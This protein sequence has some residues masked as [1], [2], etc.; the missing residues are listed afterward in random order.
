MR[1]TPLDTF[2]SPIRGSLFFL[3]EGG[4][5]GIT[6]RLVPPLAAP[7]SR[8]LL[9]GSLAAARAPAEQNMASL[10][11]NS[12]LPP[13]CAPRSAA[14]QPL[15]AEELDKMH[16]VVQLARGVQGPSVC[17][18]SLVGNMPDRPSAP[19]SAAGKCYLLAR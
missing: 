17:A 2:S 19:R 8:W 1:S 4:E 14:G 13:P 10:L 15:R 9:G 7:L 12:L 11:S 6:R 16:I 3:G 18:A 5:R